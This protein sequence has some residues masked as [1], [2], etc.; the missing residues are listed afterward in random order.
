MSA[1]PVDTSA[2]TTSRIAWRF[3]FLLGIVSLFADM[4]YE[5]ARS[6]TG[7][8]L[9]VLGASG[10]IVGFVAGFGELVGYGLRLVSGYVSD[11]TRRYWAITIAGYGINLLAVLAIALA[12]RWEL[13]AALMIADWTGKALRTPA[14]DAM[15][16]HAATSVGHGRS[17]GVHEAMD[18]V[19]AVLGPLIVAG[20]L[21][22][23][24]S[25]EAAFGMLVVPAVLA[26]GTLLRARRTYPNP[27]AL[28]S[29]DDAADQGG[30]PRAFW[31]YMVAAG[32]VA[33]GFADVPLM[34]F[35]L[36]QEAIFGARIIPIAFAI[37]MAVDALAALL[38]GGLFDRIGIRALVI[39]IVFSAGFAPFA[40]LGGSGGA[41][42]GVVLWGIGMGAQESIMRAGVARMAPRTMRGTAFGIFNTGFGVFWFAGSA[43][44][45]VLYD[46][47]P[48]ALAT[49]SAVV[50]LAAIPVLL[51]LVHR[52]TADAI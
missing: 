10:T 17:F 23:R 47:S 30:L 6:I 7:P 4:T 29:S 16:S 26:L 49:F 41:M 50:Q 38:F 5:G 12:G 33:M 40:F 48:T 13:A 45:G 20:V 8:Y 34:A 42:T 37:A 44:M 3:V 22:W 39:S 21:A 35:H 19:G 31:L 14:R 25:Y 18:Q 43:L 9:G 46:T 1:M 32:L 28:D 36:E 52:S 27:E 2:P 11:R 15:L 24:D 51:A